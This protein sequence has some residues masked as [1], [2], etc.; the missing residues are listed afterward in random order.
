M[1]SLETID[2]ISGEQTNGIDQPLGLPVSSAIGYRMALPE[3]Y[4]PDEK[5]PPA[6]GRWILRYLRPG[7]RLGAGP[8]NRPIAS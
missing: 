4:M 1:L 6:L 2:L 7:T 8:K 3:L 5:I